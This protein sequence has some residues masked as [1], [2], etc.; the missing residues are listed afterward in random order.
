MSLSTAFNVISSS[1]TANAA[2]T[3]VVSNN[4]ANVNTPG[5]SREIANVVTNSCG[6]SDVASIT[7]EANAAL[8]EQVSSSTSQAAA[9]QAISDGL[10]TLAQTVDD[11]STASSTSGANQN[12]ASPSAM[13]A[14]LQSALETYADSPTSSPAADA[15]VSAASDLASSLNSASATVQQVRETADQNMASSVNTI[16]SLLNQFTAANNAVV[17]GLQTGANISSA[18]DTR[19]SIVTQLAQQVGVSTT[20]A[21]DGSESI[22]TDSG[23]TLFQDTP[24]TVSFTPTPTLVDGASGGAVTVDGVPITGANSPM[25]IQSGALAGYAT[26]RDTLAPEYQAQLDQIA[27]GLINA[28]GESDQ[29]P[30]PTLPSLPGLFTTPGE[31]SPPSMSATTGLAAAI[32]I[33]PNVDPSQGGNPN[34]LR[35]GGISDPGNP[36]YTYNTTGAASYT[37]R[38]QQLV[39]QIGATESFDPSAGLDSSASLTDYANASVSWLQAQNQQA[40]DASSYQNAV[41]TQASSA[42]SN[43]TGVNLDAEMTNMLNLENSYASTAKLL[44]TVTSMFTALL[45]AA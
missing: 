29:S 14:N 34:L 40:S 32:E 27:G 28:F 36:A 30:T 23:V 21:A 6:G 44:T 4:I 24:R 16:N 41:A 37:G 13:L 22:Y 1:F 42:L 35:D 43:A 2:Q 7:R 25:P 39:G 5:Y 8:L 17:T 15:V 31:T 33:N 10:T 26:V 45:Q 38:I 3:G 19:D 12:G 11:S 18:E 9:Q 20:V